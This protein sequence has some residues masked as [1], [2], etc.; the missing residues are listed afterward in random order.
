MKK[1][2]NRT[3]VQGLIFIC[4]LANFENGYSQSEN[5]IMIEFEEI[6]I[7]CLYSGK[8]DSSYLIEDE[9]GYDRLKEARIMEHGCEFYSFPKVDFSKYVI[10]GYPSG[11][12]GCEEPTVERCISMDTTLNKITH[13]LKIIQHGL[14]RRGWPVPSFVLIK[15][16][17]TTVEYSFK[18]EYITQ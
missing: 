6:S 3:L 17:E 9:A 11:A 14:C 7:G 13:S 2:F 12:G 10:I 4:L 16:P 1:I 5:E 8:L 15:K 18:Y